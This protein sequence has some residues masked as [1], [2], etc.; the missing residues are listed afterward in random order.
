MRES[1]TQKQIIKYLILILSSILFLFSSNA[2]ANNKDVDFKL[3]VKKDYFEKKIKDAV[4]IIKT[5]KSKDGIYNVYTYQSSSGDLFQINLN[6]DGYIIKALAFIL[7][8]QDC[9]LC[10]NV[11]ISSTILALSNS[12]TVDDASD[13]LKDVTSEM[14]KTNA[15]AKR[16][17]NELAIEIGIAGNLVLLVIEPSRGYWEEKQKEAE[18][19]EVEKQRLALEKKEA[20]ERAKIKK[21]CQKTGFMGIECNFCGDG[22]LDPNEECDDGNTSNIDACTGQ[23]KN[24]ICGDGMAN[25]YV[26]SCDDGNSNNTDSCNTNCQPTYCGDA[27]LQPINGKNTSEEC[28]D[29]NPVNGDGC[30]TN[31]TLS[32]CGNGILSEEE[33]CDDGNKKNNDGCSSSCRHEKCGDGVRQPNE[34]CDDRNLRNNDGCSSSCQAERC[35]DEIQ[36]LNEECE[37]GNQESNDG[38]SADCRTEERI[39]KSPGLAMALSGVPPVVGYGLLVAGTL[40]PPA[41]GKRV[42]LLALGGGL[43]VVGPS[44]GLFY[45]GNSKQAKRGI[46]IRLASP[47]LAGALA[48]GANNASSS[49]LVAE[50]ALLFG[51]S[52]VDVYR[53][54][55]SALLYNQQNHFKSLPSIPENT[56]ASSF[57]RTPSTILPEKTRSSSETENTPQEI[58]T[59][60]TQPGD[61]LPSIAEKLFGTSDRWKEL[62]ELNKSKLKDPYYIEPGTVLLVPGGSPRL[63]ETPQ[64]IPKTPLAT[65]SAAPGTIDPASRPISEPSAPNSSLP[66]E[67]LMPPTSQ[68]IKEN[69]DPNTTIPTP[70]SYKTSYEEISISSGL[71]PE[72]SKPSSPPQEKPKER[73]H[74]LLWVG[75]GVGS[76]A[77]IS[78]AAGAF[79]LRPVPPPETGL[80]DFSIP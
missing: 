53:A 22:T 70:T 52:G 69:P 55:Q 34:E 61:T 5:K 10:T 11:V 76:V 64:P 58:A 3:N 24:N 31:C 19:E 60:T 47:L 36:Q 26:E 79:L 42:G 23:C 7:Y 28:D 51:S 78:L 9:P 54:K 1:M 62:W 30:D 13:W 48:L 67:T 75:I 16:E 68:A 65:V 45:A 74:T 72:V 15:S 80:G 39:Q 33:Q 6:K 18:A 29:G 73:Q 43:A 21:G 25:S 41:S 50:G 63:P 8:D 40:Q 35:G 27:I 59:Y 57:S 66:T 44:L 46:G 17:K 32:T 12:I 49:F 71:S 38:C 2:I 37:D 56:Q 77:L 14:S 4:T 20:A